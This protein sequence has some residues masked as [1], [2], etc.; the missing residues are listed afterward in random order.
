ML[1]TLQIVRVSNQLERIKHRMQDH[2]RYEQLIKSA[3][4]LNVSLHN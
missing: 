4:A 2:T 3:R 1:Q